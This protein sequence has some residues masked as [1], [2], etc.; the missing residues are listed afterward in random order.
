M[1]KILDAEYSANSNLNILVIY[2]FVVSTHAEA[3]FKLNIISESKHHCPTSTRRRS[4]WDT[5]NYNTEI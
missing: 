5:Y 3:S 4:D 2:G 1:S